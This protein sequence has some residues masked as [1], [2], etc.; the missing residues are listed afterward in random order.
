[1]MY[2]ANKVFALLNNFKLKD[3]WFILADGCACLDKNLPESQSTIKCSTVIVLHCF[4]KF[5]MI[6]FNVNQ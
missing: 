2:H 3:Y 5:S 1:M 6:L 4:F